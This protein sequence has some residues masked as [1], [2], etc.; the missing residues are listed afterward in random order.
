M[1]MSRTTYQYNRN[2]LLPD[3]AVR[4][5]ERFMEALD[6]KLVAPNFMTPRTTLKR[7]GSLSLDKANVIGRIGF[8]NNHTAMEALRV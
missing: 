8:N 4:Q 1:H 2:I 3:L 7:Q 5:H 6:S